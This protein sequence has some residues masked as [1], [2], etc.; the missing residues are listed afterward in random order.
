[1]RGATEEASMGAAGTGPRR[2]IARRS[3]VVPVLAASLAALAAVVPTGLARADRGEPASGLV[4][5]GYNAMGQLGDGTSTG[6]ETCLV[7]VSEA[8]SRGTVETTRLRE[9]AAVS[10]GGFHSLA[11]LKSGK[12]MAWGLNEE[13]QLGD[14]TMTGPQTCV[15]GSGHFV[16]A[17]S[18]VPVEAEGLD[19]V[20]A[21]AGGNLYSLALLKSGRVMAWGENEAAELGDGTVTSRAAPVEVKGLSEVVAIAAGSNSLALLKSGRVMAWGSNN[22][23]QL[24]DG[25][26]EG[27]ET[28]Y[29]GTGFLPDPC[30]KT[31]V[32]VKGL[33]EVVAI[34]TGGQD[35]LALLKSGKVMAWGENEVGEL[36]DGTRTPDSAEPVEV[37]GLTGVV[38]ITS[39]GSHSLALL[40]SGKVMAWGFNDEGQV[41]DG[42][43]ELGVTE[44]VE[45]KGLT[46]VVAIAAG[47]QDSLAL[48]KSG[49]VMAW[50]QNNYGQLGDGTTSR[51]LEPVAVKGLGDVEAIAGGLYH[52]LA[53]RASHSRCDEDES[54]G[55]DR[56]HQNGYVRGRD[57]RRRGCEIS[58]H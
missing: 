33:S 17:C 41:G 8:C 36:G 52:N 4:S 45:V 56:L 57:R 58:R 30:S 43:T 19:E 53:I 34:T 7:Y 27:P 16:R 31:P 40:K 55:G 2:R 6:P 46:G 1:M 35:S 5:W 9:V 18:T 12:V 20:A 11:L 24:G 51:R 37:K 10:V 29:L 25:S 23:G 26:T 50:G 39:G 32:E 14:G 48:L 22:A 13:G 38:A 21:I 44:P 3:R 42:T 49:K 28:C 47:A 15:S 54:R